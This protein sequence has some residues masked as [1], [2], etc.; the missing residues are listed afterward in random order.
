MLYFS[1]LPTSVSFDG[2]FQDTQFLWNNMVSMNCKT[3]QCTYK[4]PE[5]K[6]FYGEVSVSAKLKTVQTDRNKL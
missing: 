1:A 5:F 4:D 6:W 3:D 2:V